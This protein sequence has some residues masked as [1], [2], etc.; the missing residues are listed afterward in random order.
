MEQGVS[1]QVR[2]A[3]QIQV[4]GAAL[5]Q[6]K[7]FDSGH[8]LLSMFLEL[9]TLGFSLL[10]VLHQ[11]LFPHLKTFFHA[12]DQQSDFLNLYHRSLG[13][14]G[15]EL[16]VNRWHRTPDM[17]VPHRASHAWALDRVRGGQIKVDLIAEL[18]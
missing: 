6:S 13:T 16:A 3:R 15:I 5:K 14:R 18:R 7:L 1:T 11:S 12:E 17:T 8:D 10:D 9:D 4:D 2:K